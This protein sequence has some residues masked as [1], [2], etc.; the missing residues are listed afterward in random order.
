[1]EYSKRLTA[2]T[3]QVKFTNHPWPLQRR[4]MRSPRPFQRRGMRSPK[5]N[6]HSN[7]SR[8]QFPS[9]GGVRGGL[10]LFWDNPPNY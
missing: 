5:E 9:R 4:K 8:G 10:K 3:L 7:N 1:M 6:N 2:H